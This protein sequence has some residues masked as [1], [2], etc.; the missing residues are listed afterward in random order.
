MKDFNKDIAKCYS[1]DT[2]ILLELVNKEAINPLRRYN[3]IYLKRLV[4]S[5]DKMNI[6]TIN[7]LQQANLTIQNVYKILKSDGRIP[8]SSLKHFEKYCG[9]SI[10]KSTIFSKNVGSNHI[11]SSSNFI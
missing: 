2:K 4:K 5:N 10:R 8:Y 7:L 11:I 3:K 9:L 6:E 1:K